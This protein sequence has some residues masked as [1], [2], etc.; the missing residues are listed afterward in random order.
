M[1]FFFSSS[2]APQ[3][4]DNNNVELGEMSVPEEENIYTEI[5]DADCG[6]Y[7]LPRRNPPKRCC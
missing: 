2:L 3:P 1:I 4:V 5:N 6:I 7:E